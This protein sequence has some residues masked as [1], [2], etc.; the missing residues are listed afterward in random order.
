MWGVW[1]VRILLAAVLF[2]PSVFAALLTTG[3]NIFLAGSG[4]SVT[5]RR[6]SLFTLRI[7]GIEAK[8]PG[9]TLRIQAVEILCQFVAVVVSWFEERPFRIRVTAPEV[10]VDLA[11]R[12]WRSFAV[13]TFKHLHT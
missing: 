3:L 6:V 1:I 2:H 11:V 12:C 10:D 7:E 13:T 5:F 4:K 9:I 8:V